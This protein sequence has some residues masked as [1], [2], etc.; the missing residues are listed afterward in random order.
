MPRVWPNFFIVGAAKSGTT[1]LYNYLNQ[2]P[3]VYMSEVKEPHWFSRVEPNPEQLVY[4]VAS[5]EEYFALFEGW[6]GERAVGEAS[7]SYLWS[8]AAPRRI[9]ESVPGAKIIV[10]LREPVGRA[11]SHY[12]GD[13]REGLQ[14]LPFYDALEEDYASQRKGWGISHL[15][16]ELG[17]YC[18]QVSRYLERFGRENV[19]V[20]FFEEFV[21]DVVSTLRVI[22]EFL[23]VDSDVVANIRYWERHN[24][25]AVP[26]G[27]VAR[28][29]FRARTPR[30]LARRHLPQNLKNFLRDLL[31]RRGEKPDLEP[32]ALEFL[33]QIYAPERA[34][35][36]ETLGRKLPW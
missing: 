16:V 3:D 23:G 12:L 19:L 22:A 1:S 14:R 8:S 32:E 13:V 35:L 28:L 25:F 7:P 27:E 31:L 21:A 24:P 29:I 36:E 11:F 20:L 10:M 30:E 5:E 4:P 26:R 9:E 15:Y 18:Q 34:C 6:Q 2:H 33:R 17:L